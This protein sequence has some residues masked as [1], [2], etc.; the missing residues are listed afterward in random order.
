MEH[1]AGMYSFET[2]DL[3]Q[4]MDLQ[5]L[6]KEL[7]KAQNETLQLSSTVNNPFGLMHWISAIISC[8]VTFVSTILL[9]GFLRWYNQRR[10]R[11]QP[12]AP[13]APPIHYQ[14]PAPPALNFISAR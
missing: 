6:E 11:H 10:L 13:V 14:P 8:V 12:S 1:E 9:I 4:Q 2:E 5:R 7:E 3:L